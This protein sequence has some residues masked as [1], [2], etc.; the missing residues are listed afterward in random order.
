[1]TK[2]GLIKK[3]DGGETWDL[4]IYANEPESKLGCGDTSLAADK[5]TGLVFCIYNS[6]VGFYNSTAENPIC[7]FASQSFDNGLTLTKKADIMHH[8][9]ISQ[10]SQYLNIEA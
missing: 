10:S 8:N 1:M 5:D 9:L 6:Q 4:T 2:G 7:V 3:I